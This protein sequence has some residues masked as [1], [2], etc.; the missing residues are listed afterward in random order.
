VH[1]YLGLSAMSEFTRRADEAGACVLVVRSSNP[2][3]RVVL[4]A[5]SRSGV[6]V[7][8]ELLAGAGAL[9]EAAARLN[10]EFRSLL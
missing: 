1:P 9:G 7:E 6:T 3:G 4:A 8:Q 5:V 10:A 2:E